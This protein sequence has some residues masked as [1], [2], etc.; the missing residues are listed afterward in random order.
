[1]EVGG[2]RIIVGVLRLV[3]FCFFVEEGKDRLFG[4][5]SKGSSVSLWRGWRVVERSEV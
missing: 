5:G 4:F 3:S 2:S 1:M